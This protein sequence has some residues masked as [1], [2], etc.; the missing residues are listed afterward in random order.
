MVNMEGDR[1]V[2][3]KGTIYVLV[4]DDDGSGAIATKEDYENG[5]VSF[6][7]LM[8]DGRIL[9]YNEQIGTSADLEDLGACDEVIPDP[10]A[11]LANFNDPRWGND[12]TQS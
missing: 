4:G 12:A 1:W 9:R 7:H 8:P 11:H 2:R 3:F 5:E 10:I 6:A